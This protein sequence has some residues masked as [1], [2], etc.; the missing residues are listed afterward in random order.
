MIYIKEKIDKTEV[1]E[2]EVVSF[3]GRIIVIQTELEA[4]KRDDSACAQL[5][6]ALV[7]MWSELASR[8]RVIAQTT[9][10]QETV[11]GEL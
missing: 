8:A 3:P 2:M 9:R 4:E 10:T 1:A 6:N 5:F 7:S 11:Q